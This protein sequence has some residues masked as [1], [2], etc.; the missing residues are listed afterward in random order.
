MLTSSWA[1]QRLPR[2]VRFTLFSNLKIVFSGGLFVV[3]G[4]EKKSGYV[5]GQICAPPCGPRGCW[6]PGGRGQTEDSPV[7]TGSSRGQYWVRG[8]KEQEDPLLAWASPL[9]VKRQPQT[10]LL[11]GFHWPLEPQIG[12]Q[13]HPAHPQGFLEASLYLLTAPETLLPSSRL[14]R[15]L[16]PVPSWLC[17]WTWK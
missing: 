11:K 9:D 10:L 4:M 7:I 3:K 14:T 8:P 16:F 17:C 13:H 5:W 6:S 15:L 1:S 2:S 12:C